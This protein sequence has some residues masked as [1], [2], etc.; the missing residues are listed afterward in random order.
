M[1]DNLFTTKNILIAVVIVAALGLLLLNWGAVTTVLGVV[2]GYAGKW[3]LDVL[4]V[5]KNQ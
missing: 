1:E 5:T 3:L 2:L 4:G